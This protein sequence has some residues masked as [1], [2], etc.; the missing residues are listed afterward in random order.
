[1][2]LTLP[3]F[4]AFAAEGK[5]EYWHDGQIKSVGSEKVEYWHDGQIKSIG[6]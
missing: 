2:V 6:K 3:S 4:L 5:V 1:M